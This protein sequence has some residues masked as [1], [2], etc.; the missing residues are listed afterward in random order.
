MSSPAVLIGPLAVTTTSPFASD[1][2][3]P[4]K[5]ERSATNRRVRQM[6]APLAPSIRETSPSPAVK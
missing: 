3:R 2:T 6:R 1:V 4:R 5:F